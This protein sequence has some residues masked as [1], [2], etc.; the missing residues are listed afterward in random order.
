MKKFYIMLAFIGLISSTPLFAQ[1]RPDKVEPGSKGPLPSVAPVP[2][3]DGN[4]LPI[5]SM[6]R[7]YTYTISFNGHP[8][9]TPTIEC[10][11]PKASTLGGEY[12]V[13][14]MLVNGQWVD[15]IDNDDPIHAENDNFSLRMYPQVSAYRL[16]MAGGPKDGMYSNVVFCQYP[17][18]MTS[19]G[20][21]WSSPSFNNRLGYE[22]DAPT[23][24]DVYVNSEKIEDFEQYLRYRWYRRNPNTY[25]MT[26]I[27]GAN[28]KTYTYTL[29]DVGYDIISEVY[30]DGTVLD[31]SF[32]R[33][34]KGISILLRCS[35]EYSHYDGVIINTDYILP[36]PGILYISKYGPIGD[37]EYGWTDCESTVRE[38][39]PGQYAIRK[40]SDVTEY[41]ILAKGNV[42]PVF[43]VKRPWEPE[44]ADP[45]FLAVHINLMLDY[46]NISIKHGETPTKA[47]IDVIHINLDGEAVVDTTILCEGEETKIEAVP[48]KYY[49]RTHATETTLATY[50]PSATRWEEATALD[51]PCRN[52]GWTD[53]LFVLNILDKPEPL[54]GQGVIE[55]RVSKV[56]N[57][58][59][60][61]RRI[62]RNTEE[63]AIDIA[64]LL[65]D[66][67]G[68][69]VA[70]TVLGE[71]GTYRFENVPYGTYSVVV[72]ALGYATETS[73]AVTV[74]AER[75]VISNVNYSLTDNGHVV[76]DTMT[77]IPGISDSQNKPRRYD[78][79]GRRLFQQPK[80][81][82]IHIVN[83]RKVVNR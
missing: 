39:K 58:A 20:W 24:R 14:E 70:T 53:S 75:P 68:Q 12:Y 60:A 11:F 28:E 63:T 9:Y 22:E 66:D 48:G 54:A 4:V 52:A 76:S 74:S 50:Y 32:M 36:D 78:L 29:E 30:G 77:G 1:H 21:S 83:G 17:Q 49:V 6:H 47:S 5:L 40:P 8:Y 62:A 59:P 71:D 37:N 34:I 72:D 61:P 31:F 27:E 10:Q 79:Q 2:Q 3:G 43:T 73:A 69:L 41:D 45:M 56:Q 18:T 42:L 57:V 65:F 44:E 55:G 64:V 25:E 35:Y 67:K 26:P 15:R 33:E 80:Q 46:S 7:I 38:L 19:F 82:G 16:K 13:V 81:P 23:V 51:V